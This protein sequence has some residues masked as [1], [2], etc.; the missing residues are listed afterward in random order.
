MLQ[1]GSSQVSWKPTNPREMPS[2][3]A[4]LE[5]RDNQER[6][7]K[8]GMWPLK[9]LCG[10]VAQ[11][12]RPPPAPLPALPRDYKAMAGK[13]QHHSRKTKPTKAPLATM[14]CQA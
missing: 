6:K 5:P 13:N 9:A 3:L 14:V 12:Q 11:R 10:A 7:T 4:Y 1:Q 8:P 2:S